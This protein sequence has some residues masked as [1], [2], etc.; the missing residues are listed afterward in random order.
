MQ[1]MP[2]TAKETARKIGLD[3]SKSRL[4]TD[5]GYNALLG[6]TY[7]A[8]QLQRYEGSLVLAAA[9]YN[10]GPGNANKWIKAFGDPRVGLGRSGGL[11]RADPV[12]GD[13]QVRAARA[14]QLHRLPRAARRLGK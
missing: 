11:G 1:L 5:A 10:A 14:R 9:A 6:S 8:A 7:L 4:T 3:Y 12:P 13:A 2:G